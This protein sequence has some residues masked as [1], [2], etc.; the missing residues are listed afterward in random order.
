MP[1]AIG[2]SA[3]MPSGSAR[4]ARTRSSSG[5]IAAATFG[6]RRDRPAFVFRRHAGRRDRAVAGLRGSTR[7]Q[8]RCGG[9]TRTSATRALRRV[10]RQVHA[11][12]LHAEV[13]HRND[14]HVVRR[15]ARRCR[16]CGRR[17]SPAACRAA[18][19]ARARKISLPSSQSGGRAD[20]WCRRT[21]RPRASRARRGRRRARVTPRLARDGR[22]R[23]GSSRGPATCATSVCR[24]PVSVIRPI[25]PTRTPAA[26]TI[27]EGV[28][29]GQCTGLPVAASRMLAARNGKR[30][31]AAAAFSAPCRSPARAAAMR[32]GQPLRDGLAR[33]GGAEIEVVV[34]DGERRVADRVVGVDHHQAFGEVRLDAA[35]ERVAG[36]EHEHGAAVGRARGAQVVDEAAEH[37]QPA[38]ALVVGEQ[39]PVQIVGAD[40]R[41][42]DLR[43]RRPRRSSCEAERG[44][45][46]ERTT[47]E[48]EGST[49]SCTLTRRTVQR[50]EARAHR[51]EKSRH[52]A[53]D[54]RRY[55]SR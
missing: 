26:S 7:V 11:A 14:R 41:E 28:T 47:A 9:W 21:S 31:R 15:C 33:V 19:R 55:A 34:A 36:V 16:A 6:A 53:C 54:H 30:A 13:R 37:R 22:A 40:D 8:T 18:A 43:R 52:A 5:A 3:T 4:S 32:R 20:S 48:R 17:R 49:S 35:L 25:R 23:A 44:R 45:E 51:S 29:F 27:V 46:Q 50:Q 10:E 42:R 38:A 12:E 24:R 1:R 2:V 39:T